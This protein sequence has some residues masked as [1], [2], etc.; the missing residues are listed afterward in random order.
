MKRLLNIATII[1]VLTYLFWEKFPKGSFYIGNGVFI[2]LL[3]LVIFMQNREY[4]IS[5]F[6]LCISGSN[7]LDELFFDPTKIGINEIILA[8]TL[9]VIWYVK[10]RRNAR[11]IRQQRNIHFH[12]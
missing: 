9:P 4:F 1:G 2:F 11:K 6:L 5:F 12:N 8:L 10:R 7:L 3:C